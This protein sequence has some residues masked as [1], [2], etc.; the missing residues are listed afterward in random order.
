MESRFRVIQDEPTE[1]R[2]ITADFIRT[3]WDSGDVTEEW[4]LSGDPFRRKRFER[5]VVVAA[6][7]LGCTVSENANKCW[8][9]RV[10]EWV[11]NEQLDKKSNVVWLPSGKVWE[12]ES[13]GTTQGFCTARIGESAMFCEKLMVT[14]PLNQ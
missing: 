10:R 3:E 6:R 7:K 5:L 14:V 1:K 12:G 9:D 11:Q 4:I 2:K 13:V 8:L